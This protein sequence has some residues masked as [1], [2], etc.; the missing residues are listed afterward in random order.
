[1][2]EDLEVPDDQATYGA[3]VA[4]GCDVPETVTVTS[5]DTGLLI[6]RSSRRPSRSSA[7][8]R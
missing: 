7:S 8:R 3:V 4:I 5:T 6:M 2:I 1:M